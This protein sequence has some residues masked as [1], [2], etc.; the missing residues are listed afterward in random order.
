M[1]ITAAQRA[2]LLYQSRPPGPA[3]LWYAVGTVMRGVGAA[4]DKFGIDMQGDCATIE[5][6]AL[7]PPAR[8]SSQLARTIKYTHFA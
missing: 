7:A 4:L 8:P 5:K 6:R 1:S 2:N 3:S